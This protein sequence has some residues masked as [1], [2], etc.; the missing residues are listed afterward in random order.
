MREI[1]AESDL[2]GG[3]AAPKRASASTVAV[4]CSLTK[5]VAEPPHSPRDYVSSVNHGNR[6]A[7]D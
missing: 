2:P 1:E 6:A 5:A 4:P 7:L 3:T